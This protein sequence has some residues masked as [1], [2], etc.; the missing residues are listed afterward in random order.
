MT[1]LTPPVL[2]DRGKPAGLLL[3]RRYR[4]GGTSKARLKARLNAAS[5]S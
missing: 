5:D 4:A 3:W 1:G 2:G